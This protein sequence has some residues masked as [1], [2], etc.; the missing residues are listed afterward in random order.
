MGEKAKVQKK[1][2][3]VRFEDF[4]EEGGEEVK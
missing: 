3:G 4:W 1:E 2:R